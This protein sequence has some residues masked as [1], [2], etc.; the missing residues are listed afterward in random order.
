MNKFDQENFSELVRQFLALWCEEGADL[1]TTELALFNKFRVFWAQA[2]HRWTHEA[3]YS[4]LHA[5]LQRRGYHFARVPKRTW[6]G[7][8]LRKKPRVI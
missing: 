2:T 4:E 6:Y 1:H 8:K 5:E 3:S 7:L